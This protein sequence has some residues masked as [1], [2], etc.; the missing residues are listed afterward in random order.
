MTA[1]LS[2]AKTRSSLV[3]TA[4]EMGFNVGELVERHYEVDG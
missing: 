1:P 2:F 4:W 3:S